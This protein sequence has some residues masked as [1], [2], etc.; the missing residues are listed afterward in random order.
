MWENRCEKGGKLGIDE[1]EGTDDVQTGDKSVAQKKVA[2]KYRRKEKEVVDKSMPSFVLLTPSSQETDDDECEEVVPMNKPLDEKEKLLWNFVMIIGM[3][4]K[5][6]ERKK[7]DD[8]SGKGVYDEDGKGEVDIEEKNDKTGLSFMLKMFETQHGLHALGHTMNT[9]DFGK[10]ISTNLIDCWAAMLN[11]KEKKMVASGKR[12]LFCYTSNFPEYMLKKKQDEEMALKSVKKYLR[13]VFERDDML[14]DLRAFNI[15]VVP[16]IEK[17]HFYLICMDLDTGDVQVIDNMDSNRDIVHVRTSS[18][19]RYMGTPC[20]V[21]NYMW[22]YMKSVNHMDTEKLKKGVIKRLKIT[23]GTKDN[24]KDCGVFAMRHMECYK[25][26]T[27]E[28][29][30]GFS[31]LKDVKQHQ[32]NNMRMRVATTL[33]LSPSSIYRKRVLDMVKVA[34]ENVNNVKIERELKTV[35]ELQEEC[36][37]GLAKQ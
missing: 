19:F 37:R 9:L 32:L 25:G 36:W 27:K 12:Q 15:I 34:A 11:D 13:E 28:F 18:E 22:T 4:K 3:E 24:V 16:M 26:S 8:E 10:E 23:W 2:Y 35:A 17:A 31:D 33:M 7:K 20:K 29:D 6:M 14:L 5:R 21:K 1:S 30:C